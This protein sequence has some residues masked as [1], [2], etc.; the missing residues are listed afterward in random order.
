MQQAYNDTHF[1]NRNYRIFVLSGVF[2]V[3]ESEVDRLKYLPV[4]QRILQGSNA[5]SN[6]VQR[7]CSKCSCALDAES[8]NPDE[9]RPLAS[10]SSQRNQVLE[11]TLQLNCHDQVSLVK[12]ALFETLQGPPVKTKNYTPRRSKLI[13]TISSPLMQFVSLSLCIDSWILFLFCYLSACLIVLVLKCQS[14]MRQ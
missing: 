12:Y 1:L 14:A 7:V 4:I 9:E 3:M 11:Y 2:P 13:D 8:C 10:R 5:R 6:E